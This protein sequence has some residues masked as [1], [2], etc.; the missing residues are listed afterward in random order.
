MGNW[1]VEHGRLRAPR[2]DRT[3]LI[4]PPLDRAAD[5]VE[6]NLRIENQRD[7]DL[8]GRS[9]AAISQLARRELLAAARRWTAA[10]RDIPAAPPE[11]QGR[12]YLAGHQPQMFHPGV[13]FKNF[14]LGEVA[15]RH[16]ATAVNLV[17]DNDILA[18][19]ALR[20]PGQSVADPQ[21]EKIAF[22]RPDP[23]IPYEERR[24][25]DRELLATFDRRVR[26][27][28][29]PLVA[30]PLIGQYWP[31]VRAQAEHTDKLGACLAQARHQ[32][33]VVA[34][35]LET[36]EVP[37]SW[38]CGGEAFQWLV[39]H[40]LA[41]L[42]RFHAVHN[43]AVREYRRQY[44]VRSTSHP[45]PELAAEETWLEAPFWVW[46]AAEPH[47][48]RLFA[49]PAGGEIVLSDRRSWEARLPLRAEGDA[50]R[51]VER[52]LELHRGGVRIRSRAL[53]TTLWARLAL[54]DLFIH[55]IGGAKYDRVTDLLIERFL[56]LRPP[57]LMVVSATLHLPIE[58]DRMT[59]DDVCRTE[60]QLRDLTYHPEQ[61]VDPSDSVPSNLLAEKRQ[62]IE[63]PQTVENARRR[64]RAIRA[65][66]A[67][68]QP[69]VAGRRKEILERHA[70]AVHRRR[71]ESVLSWREY[72]FCLYPEATLREFLAALLH[73][74]G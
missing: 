66:N 35:G 31:L 63:T 10:Y 33:E 1:S 37:Q 12:I 56:G 51:A 32:L 45:V 40:L 62:W 13:W 47:R 43:E 42:P 48:R 24:I 65:V 19:A 27:H 74:N 15:R 17:I 16:G 67:A 58:R 44:R 14:A 41:Q 70:E 38:V 9:L 59:D 22:D 60:R 73:K 49:R 52:L 69:W 2:E 50:V 20:V 26:E 54:G 30:D 53:I 8:Q 36:L 55:G 23:K 57:G 64:C 4:E 21:V 34:W 61:F 11:G 18:E 6:E 7:Y 5:M 68:L 28:L 71:A 29:A 72:A 25:E 3:A 39:A 46:T